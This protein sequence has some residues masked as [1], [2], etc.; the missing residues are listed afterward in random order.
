MAFSR[1]NLN[2]LPPRARAAVKR[3]LGR[4]AG[5]GVP[6]PKSEQTGRRR[7]RKSDAC[8]EGWDSKEEY[9]YYCR[10]LLLRERAG[11]IENLE[12]Q[13]V[14]R[15]HVG[16]RYMRLDFAYW[17]HYRECQVWEDYKP[18]GWKKNRMYGDWRMK[19][20]MWTAGFGPGLLLVTTPAQG[21]FHSEE[22]RVKIH[23]ETLGR[24]LKSAHATMVAEEFG[25]ILAGECLTKPGS[26]E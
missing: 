19:V 6:L 14:V 10:H 26:S 12:R 17:C 24:M 21:G 23:P 7:S 20:D 11:E 1:K 3:Q 13:V 9:D 4:Q 22:Y 16:Q 5:G 15:L 25:K 18:F 2:G 8:P